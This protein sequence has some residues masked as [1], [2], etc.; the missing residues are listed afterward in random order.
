MSHEKLLELCDSW[1]G[2][3]KCGL[4]KTR[5]QILFGAG[6]SDAEIMLVVDAPTRED[7]LDGALLSGEDGYLLEDLLEQTGVALRS[8]FVTPVVACSPFIEVPATEET[9]AYVQDR[10]PALEEV[11]ACRP[12]LTE[13]IYLVDPV[14]II[15][16]GETAWKTLVTPKDRGTRNTLARASGDIFV[17]RIPGRYRPID[18]PVLAA[19][20]PK[21]IIANPSNAKH[22]P[23]AL[24]LSTLA[25]AQYYVEELNKEKQ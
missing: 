24:L 21:T 5:K 4:H 25:K 12:R 22:A 10:D 6:P 19:L 15:A 3:T 17:T 20:P 23:M 7:D 2:C 1:E 16:I 14:L 11:A 13:T 18:Y 8:V 9:K